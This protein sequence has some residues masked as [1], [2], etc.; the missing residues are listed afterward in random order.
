MV[1]KTV[2]LVPES[3]LKSV[4]PDGQVPVVSNSTVI[5]SKGECYVLD[6]NLLTNEQVNKLALL[7]IQRWGTETFSS[8]D[9]AI[10]YVKNEL[11]LE[12]NNFF[13]DCRKSL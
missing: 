2:D 12:L 5:T 3:R 11:P 9:D 4:F 1:F 13:E 10:S 8:V 7:L 6:A